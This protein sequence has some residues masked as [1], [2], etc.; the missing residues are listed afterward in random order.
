MSDTTETIPT[1]TPKEATGKGAFAA[2]RESIRA[3]SSDQGPEETPPEEDQPAV[4]ATPSQEPEKPADETPDTGQTEDTLLTT[5]EVSK[6]KGKELD[7]Y[8]KAQANYTQKTQKLAEAR[9]EFEQ[10]QPLIQAF[11]QNPVDVIRQ[12][13]EQ[14]GLKFAEEAP[15]PDTT[16][17]QDTGLPEGWEFL[18]P[19]LEARDKRIEAKIRAELGA[20]I[21]P[22]KEATSI[23]QSNAI[24][25]ETKANLEAF[26]TK[27]PGWQKHEARM[28]EEM[29][30]FAPGALDDMQA[31]EK[32]YK[33]VTADITKAE[34]VKETVNRI[35]K[36]AAAV[37]PQV[38]GLEDKRVEHVMPSGLTDS[39]K[40]FREA[41]K[42][43]KRGE[44]WTVTS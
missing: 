16:T 20:E 21:Q 37:E 27:Y 42:A 14:Q 24:A 44:R 23:A 35:N 2:A 38:N 25:A 12:L 4:E 30:Y 18:N 29:Q 8:K 33:L 9:K 7:L 17:P 31:L 11:Q 13:A 26:S 1:E 10:W 6:L 3:Q 39:G 28:I 34:Q 41:A 5:E 36:A 40:R 32:A 22:I 19:I 15:A 43:A